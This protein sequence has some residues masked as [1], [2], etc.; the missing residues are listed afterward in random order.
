MV[1]IIVF[2]HGLHCLNGFYAIGKPIIASQNFR[3][4]FSIRILPFLFVPSS[5][6]ILEERVLVG[7]TTLI[8]AILLR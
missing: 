2:L 5:M 8:I 6:S 4:S 1:S 3:K 7:R